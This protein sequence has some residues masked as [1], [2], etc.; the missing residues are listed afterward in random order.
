MTTTRMLALLGGAPTVTKDPGDLFTWPIVTQEDEEAV[1]DVLR[2]GAMSNT[3]ITRQ[4]EREFADWMGMTYGLGYCNGTAAVTAAL[5][6][7]GVGAGDEVICPSMTYWATC[8]GALTLGAAVHFADIDRD[9]LCLDPADIEQRIGPRTKAIIVVHYAG[10][11]AP[12]DAIMAIARKHG[13]KVVEDMSH[14]HGG[15]Y[16][17]KM[18][19]TFGDIAPMS[20]MSGKGFAIGEAGITVTNDRLLFERCVSYGF[21]ERTGVSSRYTASEQ[22]VTDAELLRYAGV[23]LGGAKHRMNQTCAAMG[24]VQLKYYPARMAEIQ[25]SM[26][27]FWDLLDGVPGIRAHRPP[28]DSGSTMGGWYAARGLYRAEE[29]GGLPLAKFCEAVT[30]EGVPNCYP[31]ANAPLHV[32][33]VFHTADI[34]NMGQPTMISFGQRD[35][36]QGPGALPVSEAIADIAFAIPW[37]KHDRPDE[38]AAYAAAFRKVAEHADE[39]MSEG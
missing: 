28:K 34:F 22:A 11:P 33:P 5:W 8:T 12:M 9:T 16:Q 17:G 26:H 24:R 32:H 3:E 25:R 13:V 38:I 10:Y 7:C 21:Y 23:P 18:V 4:F 30:A 27:R 35:V 20:L 29:L 1:L 15:L 37:F 6:A 14:A 36:R 2:R 31:G 39:L 19:G